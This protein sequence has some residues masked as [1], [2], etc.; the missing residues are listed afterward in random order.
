GEGSKVSSRTSVVATDGGGRFSL[1]LP[2]GPSRTI[3][4]AYVG[5]RRY[6]GS[7]A[8]GAKLAVKGRVKLKVPKRVS[9][10]GGITFKGTVGTKGARLSK[11]GKR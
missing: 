3:D 2:K 4:A 6:L 5:D 8:T 9:S 1:A 11:R 7:G 10:S